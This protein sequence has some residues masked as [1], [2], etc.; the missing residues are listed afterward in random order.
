MSKE[1]P[2][3]KFEPA[4]WKFGRI[5]KRSKEAKVAFMDLICKY[6]HDECVMT[7]EDAKLDFGDEEISELLKYKILKLDDEFIKVD[8]LD[9]QMLEIE[10]TSKKQSE[11]GKKSAQLRAEKKLTNPTVVEN[12]STDSQPDSTN[13][14]RGDKSKVDKIKEN[15]IEER[16]L[17]FASTLEPF[18]PTYGRDLLNNFYA[19]WTE[20]NTSGT[21]FRRELE[22]TWDISRRL[23]T[24]A[25]NDK[26]FT[27]GQKNGQG[28]KILTVLD[29]NKEL[30]DELNKKYS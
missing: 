11:K 8:F 5:Q 3:F 22:R 27:S 30:K 18:L 19:Y 15:N 23:N 10:K 24:W 9:D 26:K 4:G 29:I 12:G 7:L 2:Y 1:L 25:M 13:K 17:K 20:P 16:K 21:K 6:W 14:I 28:S